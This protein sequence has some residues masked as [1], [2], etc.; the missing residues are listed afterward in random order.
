M[1]LN[2]RDVI[3]AGMGTHR[4]GSSITDFCSDLAGDEPDHLLWC[5]QQLGGHK[6]KKP[7]TPDL[8]PSAETTRR[9]VT[10]CNY[11]APIPLRQ[12]ETPV[13]VVGIHHCGKP[14]Q[15]LSIR[16]GKKPFPCHHPPSEQQ[17]CAKYL[18]FRGPAV[19]ADV[20]FHDYHESVNRAEY[21]P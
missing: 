13:H 6:P 21:L 17:I 20:G 11:L 9:A 2:R 3:T 12:P 14:V 18:P 15:G 16:T 1:P 5:G 4:V 10:T 8:E 7:K 19:P